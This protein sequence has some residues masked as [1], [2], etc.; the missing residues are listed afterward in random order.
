MDFGGGDQIRF[1]RVGNAG[2]ITLTRPKALNALTHSMLTALAKALAAWAVDDSVALVILKAE[3]RAFSAGGDIL[4]VYKAGMEGRPNDTFFADEY[5][6]NAELARFPKPYVSL[7]DGIVMGG[8]VGISFHGSHRVMTE[9]AQFAMPEVGIGFFP[10]VG[11]GYLLPR[12][13]SSFGMYL[14]LTGVRVRQGDALWSGLA[15]HCVAAADL[16]ALVEKLAETGDVDAALTPHLVTPP[17]ETDDAA[18]HAI[19]QHFAYDTL[20]E[21]F[22]SLQ[23]SA[24]NSDAFAKATLEVMAGKSPTSLAVTFRQIKAGKMLSMDECMRMEFRILHRMLRAV[25][26]YEGIR[27]ALIDKGSKPEWRPATLAEVDE[28]AV[29]AYFQPLAGGELNL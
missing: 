8:G 11:G 22:A 12:L 23:N 16:P 3:G 26:F 17:R 2:V 4:D 19:A 27:A 18:I 25:D 13:K 14:G 21:V 5:R 29:E 28:A 20:E 9:N 10:D 24:N 7:I 1:E 6:F 15:T